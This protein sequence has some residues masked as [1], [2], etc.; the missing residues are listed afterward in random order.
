MSQGAA[1]WWQRRRLWLPAALFVLLGIAALAGYELVLAGRLGLQGSTLA[2]RRADLDGL[3]RERRET[4]ALAA[5]A[6]AT[7]AA[8]D[9]LYAQRLGS[10]ATRLTAVMLE[11]KHLAAQAGLSG[12]EAINYE[13]APVP[14]LPLVKKSIVFS[15]EGSYGQLRAFINLLELSPSFLSL[16]EIRVEDEAQGG[17]RLHL[18][19]RLSTLFV[20]SADEGGGKA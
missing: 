2:S 15:A 10:E 6:R 8:I 14:N 7:R 19:V 9:E 16:D 13:D 18:Q 5:R 4:E 20:Q 17:G 11:V 1:L 3:T 12:L